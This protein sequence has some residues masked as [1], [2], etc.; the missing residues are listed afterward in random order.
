MAPP[1]NERRRQALADAAIAILGTSGIHSL[2]HRAVDERA[3]LPAG[4]AANYFPTRDELLA[5]AARRVFGLHI[6]AMDSADSQVA[7][8]VD[9]DGLADLIGGALYDSAAHHRTRYLA[10]YELTLEATRRPAL[11]EALSAMAATTLEVTLGQHRMLGLP[12]SPAQ[13]QAMSTLFGGVL[14]TLV[15]GPP[16]AVTPEAARVLARC[17]VTGVLAT[18]PGTGEA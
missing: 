1:R 11:A 5:A 6:E 2:S 16:E 12:T 3:E 9:P 13:V 15:T 10:I 8:P 18:V 14:L 7:G 17:L 4:T